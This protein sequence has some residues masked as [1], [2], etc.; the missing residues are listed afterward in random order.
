MPP[1]SSILISVSKVLNRC[2]R[3]TRHPSIIKP[4]YNLQQVRGFN[5][6]SS[7]KLYSSPDA[8]NSSSNQSPVPKAAALQ[9]RGPRGWL[10]FLHPPATPGH[11]S[12]PSP[13]GLGPPTAR[14]LIRIGSS[15]D[16]NGKHRNSSTDRATESRFRPGLRLSRSY[17]RC[18]EQPAVRRQTARRRDPSG[19]HHPQ[20]PVN[21]APN[22]NADFAFSCSYSFRIR[23]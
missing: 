7:P 13:T 8:C 14:R 19:S 20:Q 5:N 11:H 12:S 3:P 4:G 22:S 6:T 23:R 9:V 2:N 10:G 1:L 16:E 18:K 15:K 21:E 17:L